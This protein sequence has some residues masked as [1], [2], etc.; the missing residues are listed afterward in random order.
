MTIIDNKMLHRQFAAAIDML[1]ETL[2]DCPDEL[3]EQPMWG[4]QA[5]Q[6]VAAGFSEFWYVGF[7]ALFWLDLYLFGAAEGF[8]PPEPFSLAEMLPNEQQPR[9]YARAELLTYVDHCKAKCQELVGGM[10]EAQAARRCRF[11]WGELTYGE[12]QLDNMRHV[13]EHG[14]QMRMFLGQRQGRASRW[15]SGSL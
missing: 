6:W 8:A 7:H 13:M 4:D 9:T 15:K 5:D 11:P 10:T 3:W 1:A 12:L 14:A 2:R